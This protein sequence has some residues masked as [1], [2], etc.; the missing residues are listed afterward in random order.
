M[1]GW[2][3]KM[4]SSKVGCFPQERLLTADSA[5]HVSACVIAGGRIYVL[6]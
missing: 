4:G 1:D 5:V 3:L 6:V 2:F